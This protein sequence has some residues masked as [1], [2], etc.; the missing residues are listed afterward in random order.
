MSADALRS[1]SGRLVLSEY[2]QITNQRNHP[3]ES[4]ADGNLPQLQP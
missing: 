4:E 3:E 1:I 2:D